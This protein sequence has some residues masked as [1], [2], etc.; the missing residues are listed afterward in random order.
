MRPWFSKWNTIQK[1]DWTTRVLH[2]V[3]AEGGGLGWLKRHLPGLMYQ[4]IERS[5]L[6]A[7][8]K[9]PIF[10]FT[11]VIRGL[12]GVQRTCCATLMWE[13]QEVGELT[14]RSLSMWLAHLRRQE[15]SQP[16]TVPND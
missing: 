5:V 12:R 4:G 13:S 15:G 7:G 8:Q 11:L 2:R 3:S 6:P 9:P 10:L 14:S 1:A 16:E